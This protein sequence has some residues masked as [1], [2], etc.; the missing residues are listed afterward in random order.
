MNFNKENCSHEYQWSQH[1]FIPLSFNKFLFYID[2]N[3][4]KKKEEKV[5]NI[6][7]V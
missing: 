3:R 4:E 2:I 5:L 6:N 7:K 1:S